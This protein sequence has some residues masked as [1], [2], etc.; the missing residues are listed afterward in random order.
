VTLLLKKGAT[1][2]ARTKDSKTALA[3]A[4]AN[5]NLIAFY[6]RP[7]FE[8]PYTDIPEAE[9]L[10]RARAKHSQVIQMLKEA[11]AKSD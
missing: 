2:N 7:R 9:L 1:V 3:L 6:D 11:G 10:K 5:V 8:P 4:L